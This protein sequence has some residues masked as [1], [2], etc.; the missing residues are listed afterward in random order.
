LHHTVTKLERGKALL[1]RAIVYQEVGEY[2][3]AEPLLLASIKLS[4]EDATNVDARVQAALAKLELAFGLQ[5]QLESL[6]KYH[7]I[8]FIKFDFILL[9]R[10]L[11]WAFF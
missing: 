5:N 1:D 2:D 6:G 7:F 8:S 4:N 3:R 11:T 10:L 9:N